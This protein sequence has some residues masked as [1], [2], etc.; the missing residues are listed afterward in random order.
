M[1]RF[2]TTLLFKGPKAVAFLALLCVGLPAYGKTVSLIRD[3]E[4]EHTIRTFARPIF[5]AAKLSPDDIGLYIVNDNSLNAF[6]AGGDN[7]FINVGLL[8]QAKTP[9]QLVGVL[10]HET[11]HITGGH[12][13]RLNKAM[14]GVSAQSILA[15][16]LGVAAV[17]VGAGEAGMAIIF[18]GQGLAQDRFLRHS[19]GEEATADHA[20]FKFLQATKQSPLGMLQ[21]FEFLQQRNGRTSPDLAYLN[22]HPLYRERV[23]AVRHQ[24]KVSPYAKVKDAPSWHILHQRMQAKLQGFLLPPA[25]M[26]KRYQGRRDL[27][28][29]YARAIALYRGLRPADALGELDKLLE[30]YPKDPYFLELAGQILFENSRILPAIGF[31]QNA[32]DVLPTSTLLRQGLTQALLASEEPALLPRALK[33]AKVSTQLA[34]RDPVG[35][36]QLAQAHGGLKQ[37]GQASLATAERYMLTRRLNEAVRQAKRGLKLL[38]AGTAAHLR[39]GD[40]LAAA[41][42]QLK[43]ARK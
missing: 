20:A 24:L 36:R 18:G 3:A 16:I 25:V 37:I 8:L 14:A 17:A 5:K 4:I 32:V 7:I 23:A 29:R 6:V 27:P 9:N 39:A 40:I 12:L 31:Y 1:L 2:L 15:T 26:I 22:T 43:K 11:G 19:R 30:E 28:A 33:N 13:A 35:W 42:R 41:K 10:A 21:I 38:P 34:P